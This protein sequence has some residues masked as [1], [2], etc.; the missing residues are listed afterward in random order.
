M[1]P[2]IKTLDE[3]G[4]RMQVVSAALSCYVAGRVSVAPIWCSRPPPNSAAPTSE[5]EGAALTTCILASK[6]IF[7][8]QIC[9]FLGADGSVNGAGGGPGG[10]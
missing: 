4:L 7:A 3:V 6:V 9:D 1:P 2:A 10:F 8:V 5:H